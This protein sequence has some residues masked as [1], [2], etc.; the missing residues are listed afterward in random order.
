MFRVRVASAVLGSQFITSGGQQEI[1]F[2]GV[3]VNY[4]A[5]TATTTPETKAHNYNMK[6]RLLES[7]V[8]TATSVVI[9][10]ILMSI[11]AVLALGPV[12][13]TRM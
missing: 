4:C 5:Q 8:H 10:Y 6:S 13:S 7:P 12:K 1:D 11:L 3:T 9:G 2:Y